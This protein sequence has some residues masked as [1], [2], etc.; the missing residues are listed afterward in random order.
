MRIELCKALRTPYDL[1]DAFGVPLAGTYK[2]EIRGIATDS[3]EVK[4][5]DLFVAL[6][7]N[8]TDGELYIPAAFAN[9][10][11]GVLCKTKPCENGLF[12]EVQDPVEALLRAAAFYRKQS[13]AY[14]IAISG[15]TGKTTVKEAIATVLAEQSTVAYSQ[16]NFNSS[17]GFPLSVLSFEPCTY[18]VAE[19]G[20]N[21]IG[22]MEPMARA[23]NPDLAV[24]TN[25]GTAHIG[26]FVDFSNLLGEKAKLA[27]NLS[28]K[29]I[30]L[31]PAALPADVF[32]CP[33]DR[34]RRV[35]EGPRSD[36]Y[37]ENVVMNENGVTGDLICPDRVI[38]NL[39]WGVPG[40][41]GQSTLL[42]VGAAC[43]LIG[44]SAEQ[45]RTGLEKAGKNSPRLHTFLLGARLLIDDTYNASPESVVGALEVL[46]YRATYRP[47][48]AV[49]GD[50]LELGNHAALLHRTVGEALVR[51]GISMLFTY[52]RQARHIADGA[53]RSGMPASVIRTFEKEE[54][55][56][57]ADAVRRFTPHNAAILF[58]ASGRMELGRIV[59]MIRRSEQK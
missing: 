36:F 51:S 39:E 3:R 56:A 46:R 43:A 5:G 42:T 49:L 25:V 34:I 38:T 30:L 9:G 37:M 41:V 10:A 47:R 28:E 53:R 14:M 7:G 4:Q 58:K 13:G 40:S 20:I 16:G 23:A 24:L 44:C 8:R 18:W 19:L 57:L 12:F 21:H 11:A 50:M 26:H 6:P 54:G 35:G 27:S 31:T 33:A 15:S 48:V 52:G 17:L 45:I 2:G 1:A 22:E 55:E 59:G 29:G 32:P